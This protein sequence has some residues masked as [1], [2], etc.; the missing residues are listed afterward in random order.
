MEGVGI[1]I[2][3]C[4][5]DMEALTTTLTAPNISTL[6]EKLVKVFDQCFMNLLTRPYVM[7]KVVGI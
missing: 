6:W 2:I 7:L 3:S 5:K 1:C 4:W